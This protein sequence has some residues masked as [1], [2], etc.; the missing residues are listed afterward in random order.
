M[1]YRSLKNSEIISVL[2]FSHPNVT[3]LRS[4]ESGLYSVLVLKMKYK[5]DRRVELYSGRN[6][7]YVGS[8]SKLGHFKFHYHSLFNH[9]CGLKPGALGRVLG[10]VN[11]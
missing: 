5:T 4:V 11:I 3:T 8:P 2:D 9:I 10:F 6:Q 7:A 1:L